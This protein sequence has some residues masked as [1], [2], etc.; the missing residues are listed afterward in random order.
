MSAFNY[1]KM[2]ADSHE[3]QQHD[4]IGLMIDKVCEHYG[5]NM[6]EWR[7]GSSADD[8]LGGDVVITLENG[9]AV[10]AK[11]YSTQT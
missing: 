11:I 5:L 7:H 9:K 6:T 4:F 8:K 2:L 10:L 3:L 1:S